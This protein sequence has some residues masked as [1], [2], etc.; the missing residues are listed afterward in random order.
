MKTIDAKIA[1]GIVRVINRIP[2][3]LRTTSSESDES[4]E[5]ARRTAKSADRGSAISRKGGRTEI[6]TFAICKASTPLLKIKSVNLSILI[7]TR[8]T[9]KAS[10]I[11]EK[12]PK[13]SDSK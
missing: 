8:T 4:L 1:T 3:P 2:L 11:I 13:I 12:N 10:I 9:E 6:K 5:T 7:E